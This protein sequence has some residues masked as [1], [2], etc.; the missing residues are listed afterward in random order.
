M[1]ADSRHFPMRL[2]SLVQGVTQ[3]CE[4]PVADLPKTV[5]SLLCDHADIDNLLL[6]HQRVGSA[7][8]YTRHLLHGDDRGRFTIVA[9]V[10]APNQQ[11][12]VHAHYTWCA[13]RIAEGTLQEDRFGW[14]ANAQQAVLTQTV[15][16]SCGDTGYGHAGMEQIHRLGNVSDT[17]AISIHV[18]GIDAQRIA[19]HVNRLARAA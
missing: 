6:P 15:Q 11:T 8:C 19:S 13:Y 3:A 12:P 18:Y 14:D 7:T 9:L 16:R 10:W 5:G 1:N 2:A 4:G 17:P